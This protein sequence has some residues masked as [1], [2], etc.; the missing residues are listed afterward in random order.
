MENL[1]LAVIPAHAGIQ[2]FLVLRDSC[3]SLPLQ[4]LG[5]GR[6]DSCGG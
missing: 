5:R 6:N 3:R 4:A 2:W 1:Y